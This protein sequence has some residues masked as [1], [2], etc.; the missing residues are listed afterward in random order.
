MITAANPHRQTLRPTQTPP[1]Q[2]PSQ[3]LDEMLDANNFEFEWEGSPSENLDSYDLPA[4]D[5][6]V[7]HRPVLLVHGFN[8]GPGTWDNMRTWL[9]RGSINKDG[10]VV[11][12]DNEP[13][14]GQGRVFA[15]EFSSPYDSIANN[16]AELRQA[17]DRITAAT[18]TPELDVVGHSMGGL[19]TRKY[20]DEGNE[21]VDKF[22]M[23]ATP[24]RGSELANLELT[25]EGM[26]LGVIPKDN[27]QAHA[28]L[29]D[30]KKDQGDQ[31]PNLA[32]LNRN[33]DRQRS[34]AD[35]L[36]VAGKGKP[37]LAGPHTVTVRGDAVVARASVE[38]P[39]VPMHNL[40]GANHGGVKDHPDSL[41]RT[42]AF[43]TGQPMPVSQE[44]PPDVPNDREVEPRKI[45]A[46]TT[47]VHYFLDDQ[48][49]S[50]PTNPAPLARG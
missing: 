16:A 8:S 6:P 17:I 24:N 3:S 15:I 11:R 22:V 28:A 26:G 46:N 4:E 35:I 1:Q 14:D 29:L 37:T 20:L 21:K 36:M 39:S 44:E 12:K 9:T 27:P 43:L 49:G 47:H 2:P 13:I 50:R 7:L 30:L 38:M 40:W 32:E 25:F 5:P 10:G 41:R 34:R 33:W 31:N 42:A 45:S 18:G 48:P 19:D 23:L